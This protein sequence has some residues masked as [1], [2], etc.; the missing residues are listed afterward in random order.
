MSLLSYQDNSLF[1]KTITLIDS[2]FPGIKDL[3]ENCNKIGIRWQDNSKP[4]CILNAQQRLL[5]HL[6]AIDFPLIINGKSY[7][8]LA[9]HAICTQLEHRNQGHFH[10]LMQEALKFSDLHY[11][12]CFLFT[13]SPNLYT[14]FGFRTILEYKFKWHRQ[15]MPSRASFPV[16]ILNFK[17]KE[18]VDFLISLLKRR[19]PISKRFGITNEVNVSIFNLYG[20][21]LYYSEELDLILRYIIEENTVVIYDIISTHYCAID[22]ILKKFN[23]ASY[24]QITFCFQPDQWE[25]PKTVLAEAYEDPCKFMLRTQMNFNYPFMVPTTSRC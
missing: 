2:C 18:D 11:A 23:L 10:S 25:I 5:A 4:F 17:E 21:E 14:R 6:G 3:A 19:I 9:L 12:G 1:E 15:S 16:K 7:C 13:E 20:K 8:F 24:S 22:D